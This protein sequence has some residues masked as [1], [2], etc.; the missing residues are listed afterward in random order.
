MKIK[1]NHQKY[2]CVKPENMYID[3]LYTFSYNPE[4]QPLFERFYK[5]KLNNLSDW[6][7]Q[8]REILK[9]KYASV[10][11]VLEISSK[12][13]F[14]YHGYIVVN[15][16]PLFI[17]HDLAKLRHY[18][19]Y[20]IDEITDEEVWRTYVY[21]QQRFMQSYADRNNMIYNIKED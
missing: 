6:S 21:K 17:I 16:I 3:K 19:T 5:M 1:R 11:V 4:D 7:N 13:R 15:N 9:L 20:E 12:G 18:G 2:S 10:D 8:C 14:H